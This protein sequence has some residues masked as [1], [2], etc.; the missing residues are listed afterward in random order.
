MTSADVRGRS[1]APGAWTLIADRLGEDPALRR[2]VTT[3][4]E[5]NAPSRTAVAKS[6]FVE[7]GRAVTEKRG[8]RVSVRVQGELD[9]DAAFLRRLERS[10]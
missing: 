7:I 2:L 5:E 3:V 10:A 8:R 1:V 4:E 9:G 6:G